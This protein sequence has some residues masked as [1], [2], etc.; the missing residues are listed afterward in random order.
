MSDRRCLLH[1]KVAD[2]FSIWVITVA[3]YFPR[4][5]EIVVQII[6]LF[7]SVSR[8]LLSFSHLI[9]VLLILFSVG[10]LASNLSSFQSPFHLTLS[11]FIP[12]A[13]FVVQL[14]LLVYFACPILY[15][16]CTTIVPFDT[17]FLYHVLCLSICVLCS[18]YLYSFLTYLSTTLLSHC[19]I[20]V[21]SCTNILCCPYSNRFLHLSL[22]MVLG[23]TYLLV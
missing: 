8:Y 3:K 6:F 5:S 19:L 21:C 11:Y 7:F 13:A 17:V 23:V 1:R 10:R 22:L 2:D 18:Q 12:L 9:F 16:F 4:W 14:L 15:S 20:L